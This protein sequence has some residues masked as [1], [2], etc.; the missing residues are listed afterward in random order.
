MK[1]KEQEQIETEEQSQPEEVKVENKER[2]FSTKNK[3][4]LFSTNLK[5]D[6]TDAEKQNLGAD[7]AEAIACKAEAES[8][9]KSF[10]TQIKA[11]IAA[12][13]ATILS[14]SEKIRKGYD[15][16]NVDC[17]EIKDFEADKLFQIRLDTGKIIFERTLENYERQKELPL[18]ADSSEEGSEMPDQSK[19]D[20]GAAVMQ[21]V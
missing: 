19:Y 6:L 21:E 3:E 15:F 18:E 4:R 10:Q 8:E 14:C 17:K 11:R 12:N 5:C 13:D 2:L 20:S 1:E 9:L 7:L 16:R